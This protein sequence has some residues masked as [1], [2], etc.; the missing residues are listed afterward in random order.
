MTN[1]TK[2]LLTTLLNA[3]DCSQ[4]NLEQIKSAF[5]QL[6]QEPELII[7]CEEQLL[8]RAY[9]AIDSCK[10]IRTVIEQ[11]KVMKSNCSAPTLADDIKQSISEELA[12]INDSFLQPKPPLLPDVTKEEWLQSIDSL[13]SKFQQQYENN[14]EKYPELNIKQQEIFVD[15]EVVLLVKG[16]MCGPVGVFR[17]KAVE[18]TI[19]QKYDNIHELR[20]FIK[21]QAKTKDI[22]LYIIYKED[23][24][25]CFRGAFLDKE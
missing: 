12:S 23:D 7:E 18:A 13:K 19:V 20:I 21:L 4:Y 2:Q 5:L 15:E 8:K 11:L 9:L 16:F 22:V 1:E 17:N 6:K 24:K 25:Y 14:K 3:I 10:D